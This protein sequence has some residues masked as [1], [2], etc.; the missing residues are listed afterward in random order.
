MQ[1]GVKVFPD[2]KFLLYNSSVNKIPDNTD[3]E[4]YTS[5]ELK[6]RFIEFKKARGSRSLGLLITN[7][8][9]YIVYNTGEEPIK[10]QEQTELKFRV[11][12]ENEIVRK[13][14]KGSKKIKWLIIGKGYK[15]QKKLFERCD[16]KK[17]KHI[18]IHSDNLSKIFINIERR[19]ALYFTKLIVDEKFHNYLIKRIKDDYGFFTRGNARFNDFDEDGY[20]IFYALNFDLK[21]ISDFISYLYSSKQHGNIVC[22]HS[23]M[24]FLG[25]VKGKVSLGMY[26]VNTD[27]YDEEYENAKIY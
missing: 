8:Y 20:P 21:L 16:Y 2:E 26:D 15:V 14:F 23:H 18:N 5:V 12:V 17:E 6:E 3:T 22:F 10:W 11:T 7:S 19:N 13:I 24:M 4:F 25:E 27:K 9:V 1:T